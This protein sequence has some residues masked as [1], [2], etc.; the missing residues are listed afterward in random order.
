MLVF[1]FGF[2][3]SVLSFV[4]DFRFCIFGFGVLFWVLVLTFVLEFG[5]GLWFLTL[6]WVFGFV[7]W[8]CIFI[9]RCWFWIFVF[10]FCVGCRFLIMCFSLNLLSG[11]LQ[12]LLYWLPIQF[13]FKFD[14]KCALGCLGL[15]CND[16]PFNTYSNLMSNAP[17]AALAPLVLVSYS[18]LIQI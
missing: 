7:F 16:S 12:L 4:L 14:A 10:Y 13:L 3:L 11:L 5:F 6:V 8:F 1:Y 18:I 17:W 15:S 9:V 2:G